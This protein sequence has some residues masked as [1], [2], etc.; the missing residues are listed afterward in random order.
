MAAGVSQLATI[1]AALPPALSPLEETEVRSSDEVVRAAVARLA[2]TFG[3]P[4]ALIDSQTGA[5]TGAAPS[6][7]SWDISSRL[8]I[9]AEVARRG[10]PDVVEHESPLVMLAVPLGR[11]DRG[12]SHVA[13]GVFTMMRVVNEAEI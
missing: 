4:L 10:R 7:P 8:S 9:L 6:E 1:Q 12:A 13:V 11:L 2:A 5:V 3:S